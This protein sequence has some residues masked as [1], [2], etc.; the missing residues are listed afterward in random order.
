MGEAENW[1]LEKSNKIQNPLAGLSQKK[2]TACFQYQNERRRHTAEAEET[3]RVRKASHGQAHSSK[4][5]IF[6][7]VSRS[8]KRHKPLKHPRKQDIEPLTNN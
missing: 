4:V 8:L 6:G 3:G 5:C 7:G 2:R 1:F